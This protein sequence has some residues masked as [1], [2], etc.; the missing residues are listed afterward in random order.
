MA[1]L[2]LAADCLKEVVHEGRASPDDFGSDA[3]L[4]S[5]LRSYFELLTDYMIRNK[6]ENYVH[7]REFA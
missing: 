7:S 5:N 3:V 6:L 2:I 1:R 4:A